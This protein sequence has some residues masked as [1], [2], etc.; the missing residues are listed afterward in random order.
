MVDTQL[1]FI[2]GRTQSQISSSKRWKPGPQAGAL[3]FRGVTRD[4][5]SSSWQVLCNTL[6]LGNHPPQELFVFGGCLLPGLT[7]F[8]LISVCGNVLGRDLN[9]SSRFSKVTC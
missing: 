9:E 1:W 7:T 2:Q 6:V 8:A 5:L 4:I 3:R